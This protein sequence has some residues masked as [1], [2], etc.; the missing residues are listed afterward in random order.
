VQAQC[1]LYGWMWSSKEQ[2]VVGTRV[3]ELLQ[4]QAKVEVQRSSGISLL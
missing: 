1:R 2:V 4:F 3:A